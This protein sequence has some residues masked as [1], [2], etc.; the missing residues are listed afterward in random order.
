MGPMGC[1][2][3]GSLV[4]SGTAWSLRLGVDEELL[5]PPVVH[6]RDPKHAVIQL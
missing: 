5:D 6:V 2:G 3:H 1:R 4:E